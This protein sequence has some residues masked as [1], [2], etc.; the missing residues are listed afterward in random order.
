[1]V[2]PYVQLREEFDVDD[3]LVI[4]ALNPRAGGAEF[5]AMEAILPDLNEVLAH[6]DVAQTFWTLPFSDLG[7]IPHL[8]ARQRG[9]YG[10]HGYS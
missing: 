4:A 1:M 10:G 2:L 6:V 5:L 3:L 7:D 8:Q 9:G